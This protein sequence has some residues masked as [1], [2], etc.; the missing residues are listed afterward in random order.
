VIKRAN[1]AKAPFEFWEDEEESNNEARESFAESAQDRDREEEAREESE[2]RDYL[3]RRKFRS[4]EE[5]EILL[6]YSP[7]DGAREIRFRAV[8]TLD[9]L[10]KVVL[11]NSINEAAPL[12]VAAAATISP[13]NPT[14]NFTGGPFVIPTNASD[15]A[16]G[17]VTCDQTQPCED[18][19]LTVDFPQ[20][21]LTSHPNDQLK[22]QISW[23]DPT[24]GQDLDT[25]LVDN[26]D[27][28]TY[29]AHAG[30]GGDNPEII[31]IPLSN[32]G[33]GPHNFFVRVAPFISTA[34]AYSGK[35]TI[36]SPAATGPGGPAPPP[37]VGIAPRYNTY[38]P[39]PGMG[40]T[41]GE[42]SIGYNLTTRRAMYISGLQTLRVTFPDGACDAL[43]EDVSYLVTKTKSL[44][45]ILFTDQRTGRTFV[46]QLNSVVPPA[47]PVLIGL[48]SL[49]A[50]TDDDGATWTPAQINPPDGSYDH[51]TVG[52]GPYPAGVPLGNP[53][54]KG[55]AIYYCSQAGVTA[56]CSRSDT[57]G[58]TFNRSTSIYNSLLDGCGGIHGHVKVALDGTVYVPNRGCNGVQSVTVSEDAGT[59]WTVRHVESPS[60]S[61]K[62]PPGI[63]DPSV[64][65]ASDGTLYF[66]WIS[67]E[68]DGGH[69]H[70]AVSHD[71][72]VT[73]TDDTDLG[74]YPGLHNAVFIEAVAGDP[75]RAAIGFVGSS[76]PGDHEADAFK[77]SWYVYIATTYDGGKTWA[78][79]NATPND[80][81]QREAGIWN[82]G[83]ASPLRNLLDFN[84]IALDEKGRV[85]YAFAD[86]CIGDCVEGGPN[87]FSSKATI[88][89][90]S[91]GKGLLAAF[92][93]NE[94]AVPQGA[95]LS[96]RRDD[97]A[98]YLKW[99]TP[100]NGGSNIT[101]YKIFR[102]T[103]APGSEV[104][105]GHT[106]GNKTSYNDRSANAAVATYIYRIVAVN[107]L[108]DGAASNSVTLS[109]TPRVEP[110]GAC[111]LPGVQV[112]TDPT[113][114]PSDS[115]AQ[116]DITSVSM[117]EP[118]ALS[119]KIVF[120]IKVAN[121]STIPSGWRWAVRFG[122]PQ[123][124]PADPVVGAQE[125]WFVSM[126]TSDNVAPAFTYGS[127]GVFQDA[128]RVFTTL[129]NLDAAS[130]AN[131]NGTITLVLPKSAIGNPTP[132]QAITSI[133]GSVRLSLP[134]ALPGTGGTN[135]TIP[136]S[137]GTGSY[138]LRASNLCLPNTPPLA[139]LTAGSESGTVPLT[140]SFDGS[141]SVDPDAIDTVASYT[142]NFSDGSD[143]VTQSSPAINHTF[144][145]PGLYPVKLVVTDSRGKTSL[146]TDQRLITVQSP[147][148]SPTPTPNPNPTPT[149]TPTAT[150][151]PTPT[152]TPTPGTQTT[153]QF[154]ANTYQ[155]NE[156]CV[157]TTII[158]TRSGPTDGTTAVRYVVSDGSATQR[159]DY[160]YAAGT[161]KFGPGETQKDVQLLINEDSYAEGMETASLALSNVRGGSLGS[162]A[163]ATLAIM[164]NDSSDGSANPIDDPSIMVGEHYHDFLNRQSD[165]GGQTFWTNQIASCGNDA[166][167]TEIKRV[168]VSAS[169]FLSIEFKETGYLVERIYKSAFGDANG[170][171]TL[172]GSHSLSVPIVRIDEFLA[173]TQEIGQGVVVLQAGWEQKLEQNKQAFMAEFVAR[174]R[175]NA[176]FPSSMSAATF[177]DTLNA[178]AGNPLSQSERDQLVS[179][180]SNGSKT[181]G[182]VL[183]AVAED[184]DLSKA[185]FNRAFVLMQYFG[186]LRRN[187]N[188][189][190]DIDHT[191]Y[192][193][194]LTKLN[195]F[196][197]N[198]IDAEMVKA[199]L[200]SIEYRE[201]FQGGASRGN[202]AGTSLSRNKTFSKESI[203]RSL[204]V[205]VPV[206]LVRSLG[207]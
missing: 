49:M 14:I 57:G 70:V 79:V 193:F 187:P 84:E 156:G 85:L 170:T 97:L 91:G 111:V 19:S 110:T 122:A 133:F 23:D 8:N 157:Q 130:N 9:R 151:T 171:S 204:W 83:G 145:N 99:K 3:G 28:G 108:G 168:D 169:F 142:F 27:D 31:T 40:E 7:D 147:A 186:Y 148:A 92:D 188:S 118:D 172:N 165:S 167:C 155:A 137:T 207:G 51:Q 13:A 15:N 59:T 86:G 53:T 35:I 47:S 33:A 143:D 174:D 102:S 38:A 138:Q 154:S 12:A 124:P 158:I 203:A 41:A 106:V 78:V 45:P 132:G 61:A 181:R 48:N 58:L 88:A 199:F 90:Q 136:D 44:D 10:R 141:T 56:F 107:S 150:P 50:Y 159:S 112:L 161:V 144:T 72:G 192:D 5:R 206:S 93:P 96:G 69:P 135:E 162:P 190:P 129:G 54:N 189:T 52:A 202:P 126:V 184:P 201:R 46:S 65:I 117:S 6:A 24:G 194:W 152:G 20:T 87:S 18:F 73:W 42:P 25:W 39:G 100:D 71:K 1:A 43:W 76:E 179:D 180:L 140:V 134:S 114:D 160:T 64:A 131:A 98:S 127:T 113:G 22:I 77:G 94:P 164:D 120:T 197:G 123:K 2:S 67:K 11:Q 81:V 80:P 37:F 60:F 66:S 182:E 62:A 103:P 17:P 146:N 74:Y 105:I 34:Q 176:A 4:E 32:M 63:L 173:D 30:N 21:Y 89:R 26:P 82:E 101:S 200:S 16:S 121:L 149:P 183:R 29:P 196:N 198:Y 191:G 205:S 153:V 163:T 75:N 139:R 36:D 195:N 95:C 115:L 175:F 68:A 104:L 177:V 185:E 109:V 178:N 166:R 128:S 125:D 55:S 119:G 116:H